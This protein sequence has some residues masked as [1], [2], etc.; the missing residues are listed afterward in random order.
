MTIDTLT[1]IAGGILL[2]LAIITP[3]FSGFF[4]KPK[5]VELEGTPDLP[6]S[7]SI[8]ICTHDNAEETERNLPAFLTQNYENGYE[9]IVV[10][11]SSSDDTIDVLKRLK[12]QYPNL[13][14]TFIPESSHYLSRRKLALTVG[15]KAAKN[16][17]IILSD[18][19]C[20]PVNDQWLTTLSRYCEND[21]DIVCGYTGYQDEAK[22]YWKFERL[23][24]NC[25]QLKRPYRYEGNN[26][27]FRKSL[28]MEHNG[29]LKNLRYLRGEY[30]FIVN[31]YGKKDRIAIMTE[32][33]GHVR[34][35]KTSKKSWR[36]KHLY[37]METRKHLHHTFV[38]R[39]LFNTD[40]L[41]LHTAYWIEAAAIG[42]AI[43]KENWLLTGIAA[44]CLILTL[45]LRTTFAARAAHAFHEHIA[46]WKMPMMELWIVWQNLI[47]L[48]RHR[49]SDKYNYIRR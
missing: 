8:V 41:V 39:L 3:L 24:Q 36:N 47:F 42:F 1:I 14:T 2:L 5:V 6:P 25:Y 11:E 18:I 4:R 30:D 19:D 44:F 20:I 9:V 35:E 45:V 23:L 38:P 13:Y 29:F 37:Y 17:W 22:D 15:I 46:V 49:F 16:E 31:E 40:M 43:F 7:F 28:F 26:L 32:A 12:T 34:Q 21:T 27:A 48:L 10:D 33:N